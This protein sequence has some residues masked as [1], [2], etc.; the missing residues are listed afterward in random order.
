MD[1][2]KTHKEGVSRTYKGVDGYAPNFAYLGHEGYALAID[3][4]EGQQHCQKGTPAF[5]TDC[6][7]RAKT[8]LGQWAQGKSPELKLFLRLDAGND[9]TDNIDI[10]REGQAEFLIKRNPRAETPAAWLA[11]AKVQQDA[12]ESSYVS[13]RSGKTVYQGETRRV[14]KAGPAPTHRV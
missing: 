2:S 14:P 5:L 13:P 11:L 12:P 1:N 6:I 10:A 7:Q 8:I 9:S 4:R 3:F